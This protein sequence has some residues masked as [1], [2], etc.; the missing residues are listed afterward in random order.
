ME[1]AHQQ[2][3]LTN[4]HYA[5]LLLDPRPT[6]RS[7]ASRYIGSA[8]DGTLGN[9]PVVRCAAATME[10]L[11][12]VVRGTKRDGSR[13]SA[14]EASS[15]LIKQLHAWPEVSPA[16]SMR[17]LGIKASELSAV[18]DAEHPSTI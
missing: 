1:M 4:F 15:V 5:A 12:T 11:A 18:G 6:M 8:V 16:H 10:E 9:T 17:A 7:S 3:S 14:R 13:R 2:K